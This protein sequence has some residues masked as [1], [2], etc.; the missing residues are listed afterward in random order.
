VSVLQTLTVKIVHIHVDHNVQATGVT[1]VADVKML[2]D[3]HIAFAQK[4]IVVDDVNSNMIDTI[5]FISI[6]IQDLKNLKHTFKE[7]LKV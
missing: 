5:I 1:M 3:D 6:I 4:I 2:M 7:T